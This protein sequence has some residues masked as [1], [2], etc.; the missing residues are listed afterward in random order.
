MGADLRGLQAGAALA[1]REEAGRAVH[2]LQRPRHLVLLRSL[3]GVRAGHRG[4]ATRSP[5]RAAGRARCR[6]CRATRRSPITS[7][8]R[9]WPT[10][11]TCRS[12]RTGRSTTAASRRCRCCGR[13]SPTGRRRSCRCRSAC[14]SSRFPRRC[15][16]TSS[17]RPA[18]GDRELS[19]GSRGRDRRDRRP[20][21][22]GAR[23]AL[24]LQQHR[25]GHA[26]PRPDREGSRSG[27]PR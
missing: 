12:S 8:R 15:A 7:A 11:S 13:T 6:R 17:A 3:L 2:D 9:W 24:R 18:P 16:A 22:P 19:R 25:V 1:G 4:D 14:C 23:R 21:P 26:V 20:V 5:T 27:S 10:S